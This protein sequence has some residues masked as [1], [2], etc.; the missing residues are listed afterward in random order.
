MVSRP[1]Q[2]LPF[3]QSR[4]WGHHHSRMSNA[5]INWHIT[6]VWNEVCFNVRVN[7]IRS[8]KYIWKLLW[9]DTHLN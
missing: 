3:D 9:L 5:T 1:R 4:D 8:I 6:D 7:L 2:V